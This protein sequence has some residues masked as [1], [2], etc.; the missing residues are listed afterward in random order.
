MKNKPLAKRL[1]KL[2]DR[3]DSATYAV[4]QLLIS[5]KEGLNRKLIGNSICEIRICEKRNASR[6]IT[7][8]RAILPAKE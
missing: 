3:D 7:S 1:L 8:L 5:G 6:A 2:T 4:A